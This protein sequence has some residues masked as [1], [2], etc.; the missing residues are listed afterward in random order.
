MCGVCGELENLLRF[1]R[2]ICCQSF[3][4]PCWT[5]S[6]S[7]LEEERVWNLCLVGISCVVAVDVGVGGFGLRVFDDGWGVLWF[8]VEWSDSLEDA[9]RGPRCGVWR[10]LCDVTFA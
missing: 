7:S 6:Y 5:V 1:V 10:Y 3:W 8:N 4:F 2:C 9:P